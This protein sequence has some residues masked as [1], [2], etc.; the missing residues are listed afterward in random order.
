MHVKNGNIELGTYA[1][2]DNQIFDITYV[3]NGYYKIISKATHKRLMC[4]AAFR[5][6]H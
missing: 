2:T 3:G 6:W 5:C 1:G 4:L